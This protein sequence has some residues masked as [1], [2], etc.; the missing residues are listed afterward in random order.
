[1]VKVS[2]SLNPTQSTWRYYTLPTPPPPF[3]KQ[4]R[5]MQRNNIFNKATWSRFQQVSIQRSPHDV[6]TPFPPPH[7][8]LQRYMQRNN[9]FNE[10]TSSR[11]QQV[12]IQRSPNDV[13]TPPPPP[14]C[15]HQRYLQRN[16]IFN[17]ATS[18]RFQ[19][20][21]IQHSPHDVITPPHPPTPHPPSLYHND[22]YSPWQD[23]GFLEAPGNPQPWT[24][25]YVYIYI[26]YIYTYCLSLSYINSYQY[27]CSS[28]IKPHITLCLLAQRSWSPEDLCEPKFFLLN[29]QC[30]SREAW[31]CRGSWVPRI[32]CMGL[33]WTQNSENEVRFVR[34]RL[35]IE[36]FNHSVTVWLYISSW[37]DTL[38]TNM[39]FERAWKLKC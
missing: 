21:S 35:V 1:M 16:N 3:C 23:W 39:F 32:R 26:I 19:Q 34:S 14:F 7:P 20:V 24:Y 9:I 10:A 37:E 5:Y 12:S 22:V 15:K 38:L 25:I 28:Y 2:T 30:F 31:V 6:I 17:E 33:E 11:F 29:V 18:S 8:L 4:Q 27:R 13:I 36:I